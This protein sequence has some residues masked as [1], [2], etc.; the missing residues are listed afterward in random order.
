[1]LFLHGWGATEPH[2][3]GPWLE[4]L[5]RAGN[6]VV[7]PRYQDSFAEPPTQVLG[8]ALVGIR[9]ALDH[10]DVDARVA[11]RRRPLGRRRRWPPTTPRSPAASA[12]P[13]RAR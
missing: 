13:S 1:M 6:A 10:T 7:Y 9:T 2:F 4:H 5:A 8:N 12:C 11:R 3:Y